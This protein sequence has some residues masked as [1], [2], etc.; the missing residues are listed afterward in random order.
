VLQCAASEKL[1]SSWTSL[2]RHDELALQVLLVEYFPIELKQ[3]SNDSGSGLPL[4][5]FT[6]MYIGIQNVGSNRSVALEEIQVKYWFDGPLSETAALSV[7]QQG[8][9]A[10]NRSSG[11]GG[12][13]RPDPN[14]FTLTCSDISPGL[15]T[16]A[17]CVPRALLQVPYVPCSI[18]CVCIFLCS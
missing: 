18:G 14:Q 7:Q 11:G 4:T 15:G 10:G 5:S 2:N 8:T 6:Q 17:G 16:V 1:V 9:T 12:A 13:A 3:G